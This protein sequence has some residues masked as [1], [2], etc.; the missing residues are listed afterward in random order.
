MT[1]ID[2]FFIIHENFCVEHIYFP[3][4]YIGINFSK[5]IRYNAFT[6]K[7]RMNS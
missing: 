5:T 6:N 3:E 7:I 1:L 4:T 2:N